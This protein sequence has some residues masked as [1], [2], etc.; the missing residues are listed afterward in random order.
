MNNFCAVLALF[1]S[2]WHLLLTEQTKIY[3]FAIIMGMIYACIFLQISRKHLITF[4]IYSYDQLNDNNIEYN[5]YASYNNGT[6]NL[7]SVIGVRSDFSDA[8]S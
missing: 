5:W 3:F 7:S 1:H 6:L 2:Y 8:D 4:K